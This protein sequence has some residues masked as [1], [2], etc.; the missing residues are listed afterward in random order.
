MLET[1]KILASYE[2]GEDFEFDDFVYDVKAIIKKLKTSKFFAYGLSLTWRNVAGYTQFETEDA[3]TLIFKLAPSS[4]DWSMKFYPTENKGI[5]E[6]V[7][8][9]HDKPMGETLYLMSQ[10]RAKK[11]KIMEEYFS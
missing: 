7:V 8:Y 3:R 6:V 4:G 9:H 2:G 1:K 11:E 5:I 10:S